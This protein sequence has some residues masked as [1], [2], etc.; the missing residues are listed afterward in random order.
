MSY[1]LRISL[2]Y[3]SLN[4]KIQSAEGIPTFRAID[5]YIVDNINLATFK[6]H[7]ALQIVKEVDT[8]GTGFP[9]W[10]RD[11]PNVEV[12]D[13]YTLLYDSSHIPHLST[14]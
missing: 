14:N 4:V 6:I 13:N 12:N 7:Q 11:H 5:G 9:T 10:P 1:I 2:N 8:V 3:E